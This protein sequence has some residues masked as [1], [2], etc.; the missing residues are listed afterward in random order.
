VRLL[1]DACVPRKLKHDLA[2]HDVWTA[3]E[4]GWNTLQDGPLLDVIAGKID[5]LITTDRGLRFQQQLQG[6]P[7]AVVVLRAKSNRLDRLQPLVPAVLRALSELRPGEVR[8]VAAP[9]LTP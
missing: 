2:G 3:R 8:E 1:L 9:L 7:F 4:R 6:R 5:A